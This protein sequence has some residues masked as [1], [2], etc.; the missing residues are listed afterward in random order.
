MNTLRFSLEHKRFVERLEY[1]AVWDDLTVEL[2]F[3]LLVFTAGALVSSRASLF[4]MFG[5]LRLV[6][7]CFFIGRRHTVASVDH[8]KLISSESKLPAVS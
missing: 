6:Y 8:D 3:V 4:F 1:I 5:R 7:D 2:L